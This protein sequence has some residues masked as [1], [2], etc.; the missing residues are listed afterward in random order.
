MFFRSVMSEMLF[1]SD[2]VVGYW[3]CREVGAK[4]NKSQVCEANV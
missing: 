3:C 2:K 1:D 4:L